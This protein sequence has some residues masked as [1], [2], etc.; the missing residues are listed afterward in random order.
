[1]SA[2]LAGF[3]WNGAVA[4]FEDQILQARLGNFD[5]FFFLVLFMFVLN[6]FY[7]GN[8]F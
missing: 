1:M 6:T 4:F 2:D 5:A 7:V 8:F 3:G